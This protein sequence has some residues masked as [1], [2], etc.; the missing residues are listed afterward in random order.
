MLLWG[1]KLIQNNCSWCLWD[2]VDQDS[3]EFVRNPNHIFLWRL[4]WIKALLTDAGILVRLPMRS[5]VNWATL[6]IAKNLIAHERTKHI[7]AICHFIREKVASKPWLSNSLYVPPNR[8]VSES[9]NSW[10]SWLDLEFWRGCHT[11]QSLIIW[12]RKERAVHSYIEKESESPTLK[13]LQFAHQ[14]CPY[15]KWKINLFYIRIL[16]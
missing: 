15:W 3:Y 12:E 14:Y 5:C 1:Q 7:E 2:I 11:Q 9:S 6:H 13:M 16:L 8:I 10:F 4:L